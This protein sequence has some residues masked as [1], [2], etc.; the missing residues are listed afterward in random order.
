MHILKSFCTFFI[1][2]LCI[3]G[4][5][6][7]GGCCGNNGDCTDGL[8]L[9]QCF[10]KFPSGFRW[11]QGVSC[12]NMGCVKLPVILISFTAS[13]DPVKSITNLSWKTTQEHNSK[14]FGI[15]RSTDEGTTFDEIG[16]LNAAGNSSIPKQYYFTDTKP[17]EGFNLYRLK[18]IDLD[19][20]F[21]YSKIV[22]VKVKNSDQVYYSTYPNPAKGS[23]Y[24]STNTQK[25]NLITLQLTDGTGRV[26]KQQTGNLSKASPVNFDLMG[27][28]PGIYSL[29]IIAPESQKTSRL[30]VQ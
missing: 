9:L 3:K 30:V 8:T 2:C 5:S 18:Q 29:R 25:N 14:L 26:L 22:F 24:I 7:T 19:A 6:Q 1:C 15:E 13:Y 21:E 4:A 27:I 12:V 11:E 10:D 28:K 16:T 17:Q 20:K 23:V